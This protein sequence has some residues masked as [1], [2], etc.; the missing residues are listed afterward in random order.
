M[1]C[2]PDDFPDPDLAADV[3]E[4]LRQLDEEFRAEFFENPKK[5]AKT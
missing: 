1:N 4:Y 2:Y 3:L 5:E